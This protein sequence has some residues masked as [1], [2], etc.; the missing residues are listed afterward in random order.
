MEQPPGCATGACFVS[1][2]R[3]KLG[4]GNNHKTPRDY[5]VVA[6]ADGDGR[7]ISLTDRLMPEQVR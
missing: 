2:T 1:A 4:C 5:K 3:R 6:I 7:V